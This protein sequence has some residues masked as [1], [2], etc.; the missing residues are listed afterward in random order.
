MSSALQ[1]LPQFPRPTHDVVVRYWP[2]SEFEVLLLTYMS[3]LDFLFLFLYLRSNEL[4][5]QQNTVAYDEGEHREL[6]EA[7]VLRDAISDLPAVF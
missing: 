6:E 3:K 1:K 4:H 5:L 2:P 7:A